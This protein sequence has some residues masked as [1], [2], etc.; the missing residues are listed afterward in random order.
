MAGCHS[1]GLLCGRVVACEAAR[2][3]LAGL[4]YAGG[5]NMKAMTRWVVA[6]ALG[7]VLIASA[8]GA[9]TPLTVWGLGP[10]GDALG[11]SAAIEAFEAAH[12]EW[13]VRLVSVGAGRM[14]S[15]KLLTG[16]VGGAPPDVVYQDRFA[17]AGWAARG[18]FEALDDRIARDAPGLLEDLYPAPLAE[19]RHAGSTYAV[20]AAADL[21]VLYWNKRLFRAAGLDPDRSPRDWEER[22]TFARRLTVRGASGALVQA[23]YIPNGGNTWLYLYA[24]ALG[25]RFLSEDGRRCT[26]AAPENVRALETMLAEY[27]PLGGYESGMAFLNSGLGG[28]PFLAGRLAMKIDGNW[29][30]GQIARSAPELEFGVAAPPMPRADQPPLT[31]SGGFAYAIPKGAK[32]PEGA[33]ALIRYLCS[34]EGRLLRQSA[35]AEAERARGRPYVPFLEASREANRRV[36]AAL[37]PE[38]PRLAEALM[39]QASLLERALP[40]DGGPLAQSMWDAQSRAIDLAGRGSLSPQAALESEQATLQARLDALEARSNAPLARPGAFLGLCAIGAGIAVWGW[41]AA[42]RRLKRRPGPG[43]REALWG[44][45][46]ISPWLIGFAAFTLGPMLASLY[47][48]FTDADGLSPARWVGWGNYAALL[49]PQGAQTRLAFSN[50]FYLA[51]FGVPLHLATGL[52]IALLLSGAGRGMGVF[53]TIFY[54]PAVVPTVAAAILWA[55]LLASDPSQGLV[56]RGFEAT[57]GRA[58]G[59]PPPGWLHSEAW[60]KPALILMGV[61]GAGSGMILWLAG[62]RS[63]PGEMYEA[64]RLEGA[65][66]GRQFA[67]LTLPHLTPLLFFGLVMGVLGAMQEFDRVYVMRPGE[68]T[69]G[70]ADALLTPVFLLYRTGFASFQMGLASALAWLLFGVALLATLAQARWAP[71]WLYAEGERS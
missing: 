32:H 60:A 67:S 56:N 63:V 14:N 52:A 11:L 24:Q 68:A 38:E 6:G 7:L 62:L 19:V 12:P 36:L 3:G 53:R 29:I 35:Q 50:A 59:W 22:D 17:V 48:S 5:C 31:W 65:G 20:P 18:A 16:I 61:W 42:L 71:R 25:G 21:R 26:L 55:W 69:A 1:G 27:A 4:F 58:F 23:G 15:Q 40:R 41:A 34:S 2:R 28:D 30:L 43:Y 44:L 51:A 33:W 70:P 10:G 54:L 9:R 46:M 66:S 8:Q 37:S 45:A 39:L 49:G 64:A 47:L 57:L 13:D